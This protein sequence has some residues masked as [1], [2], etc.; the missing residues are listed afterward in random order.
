ML[1]QRELHPPVTGRVDQGVWDAI[2]EQYLDVLS[3]TAPPLPLRGFPA[4]GHSAAPGE[5]SLHLAL[6]QTMLR[7]LARTFPA[8]TPPAADGVN[9]PA[10]AGGLRWVQRAAGL[11]QTGYQRFLAGL[12]EDLPVVN[13][14]GYLDGDGAW[15]YDPSGLSQ[16]AQAAILDYQMLQYNEVFD[17][18]GNLL[19]DFFT[20]PAS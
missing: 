12:W 17:R 3:H 9:G 19:P 14:V 10:T 7:G 11:P 1:F 6:A 8:L 2:A 15:S 13:A 18:R 16:A 4:G 20:L 5:E